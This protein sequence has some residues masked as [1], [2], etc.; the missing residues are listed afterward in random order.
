MSKDRTGNWTTMVCL[1]A[2]NYSWHDREEH[3]FYATQ[4]EAI[5]YLFRHEG[6]GNK[7]RECSA[8]MWHLSNRMI[9]YGKTVL[10]SDLIDRGCD[11][12]KHGIDFLTCSKNW[13]GDIIT[14]P[15]YKYAK[16]FI[17]KALELIPIWNKVA[18]FLRV[19]F[20]ESKGRYELW[21]NNPPKKI[22]V[23]SWRMS[24]AMN[25]DFKAHS[26]F[27]VPYAWYIWEKW[28]NWSTNI[29]RALVDW[30]FDKETAM[31]L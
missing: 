9:E 10:A 25:W 28:Y 23:F 1:W 3:D 29:E 20:L 13:N 11:N 8:W 2:H 18:M 14:N 24:C 19:Q 27:A 16:E 6:F 4:P 15:P 17:Y 22:L 31:S 21:K 7:I 26:W 30:K 12:I 5:D